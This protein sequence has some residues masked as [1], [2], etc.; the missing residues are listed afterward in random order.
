MRH[1]FNAVTEP[2]EAVSA[3]TQVPAFR[4]AWQDGESSR[5]LYSSDRFLKNQAMFG[6][7]S[8]SGGTKMW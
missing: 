6:V 3:K 7:D 4:G 5:R 1:E 2:L 8:I